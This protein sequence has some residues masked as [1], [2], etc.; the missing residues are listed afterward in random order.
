MNLPSRTEFL[1]AMRNPHVCLKIA[2]LKNGKIIFKG[3]RVI[4]YAGGYSIVF[5]YIK[6]NGKKIAV[7]CWVADIG[8]AKKRTQ[9][10]SNY[11]ASLNSSY[12]V[13]FEYID[14]AILVNGQK[15]PVVL[16]DWVDGET[17][18]DYISN[19]INNK[20]RIT[21]LAE[22]FKKMVIFFHSVNIAHGDLQH[23]NIVIN[24]SAELVVIDYDSMFVD[25]LRGMSD[26][27]KGLPGYQH[28]ARQK[29]KE[30]SHKADY[31]SELIVYLSLLIFAREPSLWDEYKDTEDLLFSSQD[32]N[33]PSDSRLITSFKDSNDQTISNLTNRLI[34][35]LKEPIIE[36]LL[37][38]E[39]ILVNKLEVA[40]ETIQDKWDKQPNPPVRKEATK[41][42]AKTTIDKFNNQPNQ[43]KIKAKPDSISIIDKM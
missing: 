38:L 35:F 11:L 20:I 30:I 33:N 7:R 16:M 4:T 43:A 6:Q 25:S 36:N 26:E 23:G 10:I 2:A 42:D 37:P 27:V 28:P 9:A 15:Y 40:K 8:N 34:E 22:E 17:L 5:P 19:N 24:R 12:F 1:T 13:D 31:F 18:K 3:T 21:Q 29:T 39:D 32:F 41:S 14:N